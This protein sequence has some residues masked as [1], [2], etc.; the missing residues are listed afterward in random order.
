MTNK[1]LWIAE[2]EN[3]EIARGDT[4]WQAISAAEEHGFNHGIDLEEIG[5]IQ[6]DRETGIRTW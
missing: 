2:Y 3:E 4:L 6:V 5:F 1:Y